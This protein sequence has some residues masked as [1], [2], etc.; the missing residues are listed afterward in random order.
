MDRSESPYEAKSR[1][2]IFDQ[3]SVRN[4]PSQM[5]AFTAALQEHTGRSFKSYSELH[6]FSV[7]DYRNFWKCFMQWT[8]GLK[9]SGSAET[10][11]VGD[12][13][14]HARFFPDVTLNYADNLL[15]FAIAPAD[16]PALTACHADG[17]RVHL[18]RGELRTRVARLADALTQL[19]LREGDRVAGVMRNDAE[20]IVTALAVTAIGAT[21]STAAPEMGIETLLDRFTQLEPRFLFAH[22]AAQPF[23]TGTP[24]ATK[25]G[26][27]ADALP[28]LEGIV[29]LDGDPS[30]VRAAPPVNSLDALLAAGD[31]AR[32]EWKH[33]GFNHP[34][35]VMFSSGTTG[36]PKCIVHGA[37]GS[38]IEHLKEHRLHCDLRPGD[39]MYFHTSCA[40]MMWNWQLSAL[41]SGVEIVTYDGP[42]ASVD[43]LWRLVAEQRVNVFG[44][45]PAY[46]KMCED[47]G[48]VP[49]REF[50]LSD[51]RSMMSTGAILFDAQFE[52]VRDNVKPL[53]LQS[54]SGGTDILGCFVLGNPD[55]PVY[56]GEAQCKSLAF[57]VQAWRDGARAEGVGELVCVNPFPSRP[58]G[59]LN[60]PEGERFHKAYFSANAGVWTH[61]DQIEFPPEG[62]ARLHGRSDGVLVVRGINVG[63]DEI[64]RV[65]NDMPEIREGIVVQQRMRDTS[66]ADAPGNPIGERLVLLV[67]LKA[68][69]RMNGALIARIRRELVRRTSA[70]HVPDV[71]AAVDDLPVTHSGKLTETAVRNAVNG[72]DVTNAAALRNPASLDAIRT[73]P[74]LQHRAG[75]VPH[76]YATREELERLLQTKWEQLFAFAPIGRDDNFFELGGHSLLAARLL[77]D[78]QPIIGRQIPLAT[79]LR[80]PTIAKLADVIDKGALPQTSEVLVPMREGEGAPLFL[81]H[82]VTGS[83][84]ECTRLIGN[85]R[86]Q[87]PVYG[88]QALGLDGESAPQRRVEDMA[89]TYIEQIR[90]VQPNGPYALAGFSFGGL[91]ALEIAQQL[92]GAGEQTEFVCLLDTYVQERWLPWF[93]LLA[94]RRDYAARL[95]KTLAGMSP[96]ERAAFAGAKMSAA[97]N[98]L[99][100]RL[101]RVPQTRTQT[102]TS[103][104]ADPMPPVLRRM[105][106]TFRTAM[107][108]YRPKPFEGGRIVYVR[109]ASREEDRGD[110]LPL[111]QKIA[112]GGLTVAEVPGNHAGVIEEPGVYAAAAALDRDYSAEDES[113][114]QRRAHRVM[115]RST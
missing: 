90:K 24:L 15:G 25:V 93:A 39:R 38:L 88:L 35:F 41:A 66:N 51:L 37:G 14:E 83:V 11:C 5:A 55:L 40:W 21:L 102:Q 19:G 22:T 9:W 87:R 92:F 60:D 26:L 6:D 56:A 70:A 1:L 99:A 23:D 84:L 86:K 2:P 67:T 76:S 74:A 13:G 34:L 43:T 79:M 82:S 96:R 50:D 80:A 113:E 20:A 27:L 58:L 72:L 61:G 103:P 17:R 77:A 95:L 42:I 59:F 115:V 54:I 91:I 78:L 53:Q 98:K 112:R 73:H 107:N 4:T 97:A 32:V 36:K 108:N 30:A 101:G 65:L 45:S 81:V 106:D 3:Q 71:I 44:T 94:F 68:G 46:L 48:L 16:A 18:T 33:F 64:Y 75:D 62:T 111:W 7:R 104:G 28:S 52:W 85:M 63:P 100:M 114:V 31:P 57:D 109:A 47:A 105:R 12:T 69:A 10:V 29:S 89:K 8:P 49:S 110:P